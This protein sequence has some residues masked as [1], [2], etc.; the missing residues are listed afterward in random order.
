M[1]PRTAPSLASLRS[2]MLTLDDINRPD[3]QFRERVVI[4]LKT[5]WENLEQIDPGSSTGSYGVAGGSSLVIGGVGPLVVPNTIGLVPGELVSV[6]AESLYR[7]NNFIGP[8]AT[9]AVGAVTGGDALLYVGW[10]S[11]PLLLD[12]FGSAAIVYLSTAGKATLLRPVPS[13]AGGRY[14][15][16]VGIRLENKSVGLTRCQLMIENRPLEV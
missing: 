14:E 4:A 11:G 16:I 5:M 9:H 12:G 7:A 6:A 3:R 13:N 15:Q 2:R 1:A 8:L 10:A